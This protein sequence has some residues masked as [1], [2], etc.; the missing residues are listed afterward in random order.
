VGGGG[1]GGGGGRNVGSC[2]PNHA[3]TELLNIQGGVV[4]NDHLFNVYAI[5]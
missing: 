1:G 5:F 2:M 4:Y 3:H